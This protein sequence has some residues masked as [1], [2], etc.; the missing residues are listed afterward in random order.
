MSAWGVSAR[1][2]LPR[3]VSVWGEEGVCPRRVSTQGG[4]CTGGVCAQG[5][6]DQGVSALGGMPRGGVW[7]VNRMTD[8]CKTLP[9]HNY[10]ADGNK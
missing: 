3:R 7:S 1:G 2:Y 4:I 9:C 6:S 8:R 5:V 10:V